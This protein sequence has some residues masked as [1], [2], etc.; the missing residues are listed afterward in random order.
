MQASSVTWSLTFVLC[1]KTN[2]L[3]LATCGAFS[4]S[5]HSFP[6]A[7]AACAEA[8]IFGRRAVPSTGLVVIAPATE[9]I[10]RLCRRK[11]QIAEP[12]QR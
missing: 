1:T 10:P 5:G 6:N 11:H 9:A 12:L 7:R 3:S 4:Y 2:L 8:A